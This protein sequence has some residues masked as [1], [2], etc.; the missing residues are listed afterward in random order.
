QPLYAHTGKRIDAPD[1]GGQ[2]DEEA[3]DHQGVLQHLL[4]GRPH[5]LFHLG[6]DLG[7]KS[8]YTAAWLAVAFA[9]F[10][11]HYALILISI[12]GRPSSTSTLTLACWAFRPRI[13]SHSENA[14]Q[15]KYVPRSYPDLVEPERVYQSPL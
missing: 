2:D 6:D 9:G 11:A 13:V 3:K 7:H 12:R 5:H 8:R 10:D 1:K 15:E 14:P 4:R